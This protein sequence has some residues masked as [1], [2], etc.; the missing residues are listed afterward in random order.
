MLLSIWLFFGTVVD[1]STPKQ[2]FSVS[3]NENTHTADNFN[4]KRQSNQSSDDDIEK[5]SLHKKRST[6]ILSINLS[7]VERMKYTDTQKNRNTR[8]TGKVII[9]VLSSKSST[10]IN[11][12]LMEC[13]LSHLN[14]QIR[15]IIMFC[16]HTQVH[17]SAYTQ[18]SVAFGAKSFNKEWRVSHT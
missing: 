12:L 2:H 18:L 5:Y 8:F 9:V 6:A 16:T 4:A 1:L 17:H 11:R 15:L 13:N 14:M 3:L 10:T 7:L